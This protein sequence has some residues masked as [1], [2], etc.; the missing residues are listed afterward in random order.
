Y[1]VPV[2]PEG[3]VTA[4]VTPGVVG[5][6]RGEKNIVGIKDSTARLENITAYQ[7]ARQ[8]FQV[9]LGSDHVIAGGLALGAVGSITACGNVFPSAVLQVY[10][11]QPGT[12]REKAQAELSLLRGVLESVPGKAVA[13]QKLLL[14]I[15]G[16]VEAASPV[17]DAAK[18]LTDAERELILTLLSGL[19][20]KLTLNQEIATQ[21]KARLR[22]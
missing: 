18:Q 10:A 5:A 21:I 11:P 1:N 17:R 7:E 12:E 2:P 9:L 16:V 14:D 19:T 4:P 13:I 15:L 8:D 3:R 20:A 6:L 22:S